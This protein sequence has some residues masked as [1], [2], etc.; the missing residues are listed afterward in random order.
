MLQLFIYF[1]FFLRSFPLLKKVAV[2]YSS[3]CISRAKTSLEEHS[4]HESNVIKFIKEGKLEQ[5]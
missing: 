5:N 1:F 4:S 2:S 3:T